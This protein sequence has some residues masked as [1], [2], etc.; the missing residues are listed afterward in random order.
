VR[1]LRSDPELASDAR[2]LLSFTDNRQDAS[3]QA[4]HFND[5]VQTTLLRAALH[6][7]VLAAGVPGLEH[8]QIADAVFRSLGLP[9]SA[10]A[11]DPEVEF[12]AKTDTE[13]VL[14]D[15]L[16]YLTYVDLRR[17]WRITSPN[18][19]QCGLLRIE[20][21]SLDELCAAERVWE[22]LHPAL[23]GATPTERQ[24]ITTTLLDYLR[25]ELAIKVD[26][27]D[28]PFQERLTQRS[29][30]RLQG[31]WS[32]DDQAQLVYANAV[33]PR[34]R[35]HGD[36]RGWSY[37]SSRSGFGRFLRRP[38]TIESHRSKLTMA[39]IDQMLL[40]LFAALK[41]AGLV[42][43]VNVAADGVGCFQVP[44]SALVWRVGDGSTPYHDPVR[45]PTAPSINRGPQ[46]V[47]RQ[48][49]P[50]RRRRPDR[51]R[52]PGAHGP[53]RLRG[54]G[55]PASG[56]SGVQTSRCS[57]ARRRWSSASTSPTS[58]SSTCATSRRRRRTTRS[59]AAAP[60]ARGSRHSST[61]TAQRAARTTSGS[62]TGPS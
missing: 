33:L 35:R 43:Q 28:Q 12:A 20:Y 52:G 60:V 13:R 24:Y 34:S 42:E 39:D 26:Y 58:M 22:T 38:S 36:F 44:A 45:M 21:Q 62:S 31:M 27:L 59:G 46:R 6:R 23:A 18:L 54:S 10:Y 3:L 48:A 25:R 53:G 7:A 14:R 40:D 61:P 15:V 29:S 57:T 2:K 51:H 19:E 4:G 30:Q 41:R 55:R 56:A 5:F 50:V 16:G 8:D 17:G 37:L 49:L 9:L 1:A 47:L 11:V 32:I